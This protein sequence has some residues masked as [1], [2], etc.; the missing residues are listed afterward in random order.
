MSQYHFCLLL[1]ISA[2]SSTGSKLTTPFSQCLLPGLKLHTQ[3][4]GGSAGRITSLRN[5]FSGFTACCDANFK[6]LKDTSRAVIATL[7]C[8]PLQRREKSPVQPN[9]AFSACLWASI[10]QCHHACR[11]VNLLAEG[12]QKFML[13]YLVLV[14]S[15]SMDF[16][17]PHSVVYLYIFFCSISFSSSSVHSPIEMG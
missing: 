17:F 7:L 3:L 2:S 11:F 9:A 1:K 16:F 4:L 5:G 15:L 12:K 6:F 10:R 14:I 13:S 8:K